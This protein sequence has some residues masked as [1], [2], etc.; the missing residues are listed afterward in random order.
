[1]FLI[2][3]IQPRENNDDVISGTRMECVA[4]RSRRRGK[5]RNGHPF[6]RQYVAVHRS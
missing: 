2:D 5:L 4:N 6:A 3:S 1:M